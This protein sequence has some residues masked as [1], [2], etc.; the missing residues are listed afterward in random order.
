MSE[1][2]KKYKHAR[3]RGA[4]DGAQWEES[5]I[6]STGTRPG[7]GTR[8]S[9]STRRRPRSPGSLHVGHVL[10][11]HP[12]GSDRAL[13]AHAGQ[14]HRL[15]HGVGRQRPAHRA[16]GAE[17]LRHP[18][19]ARACP[20]IPTGSRPSRQEARRI[21]SR[22]SLAELHRGL[23][24]SITEEDEAASRP[25]GASSAS[26]STGRSSTPRSTSTA[27]ARSRS[28]PS[29]TW[30]RRDLAYS[31][32]APTMWDIDFKTAV[33]QAE[34]EDK[35]APRFMHVI[36]FASRWRSGRRVHHHPRR[37]P[38]CLPAC[39]AVVA[40]PDDERYK[41]YF[42]KKA[43]TPLFG[44]E[45]PIL[46]GRARRPR[47][48]HRASSWSAPSATRWTWSGGSTSGLALKQIIGLDGRLLPVTFGEAPFESVDAARG[49]GALRRA[50]GPLRQAGQEEASPSSSPRTAPA[51]TARRRARRRAREPIDHP[52]KFYEK[53][54]RPLEF[55][56]TRQ[57][58]VKIL[59]H[60]D[61][62]LE[63]GDKIDWHPPFMRTATTLGR[64]PQPGLVHQPPALLR[65]PFPGLVRGARRRASPIYDR[66][67][68]SPT[69]DR[70]PVDPLSRDV[71][72]GTPRIS[73][74]ARRLHGRP[75]RH[76]HLGDELA[77]AADRQPLGRSGRSGTAS[78][79]PW[80]CARSAR[81]H[82][83]L[84]LLHHREGLDAREARSP[85]RTSSSAGGSS[86]PTARR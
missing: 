79:S 53:G 33:A 28:C 20:T 25:S 4:L 36:R 65:R 44:A 5:G 21:P 70:L 1:I 16:P 22:R 23:R 13:P 80:T 57:W 24:R 59:E 49:A 82:P 8:R 39:I 2:P 43:I 14:E 42:G 68:S 27:G 35:R 10:Q 30:S 71:L 17:H 19:R 38:S 48:G 62:L 61:E 9:S 76:G 78:S 11:L 67:R 41:P 86:I 73:A 32:E 83:H 50:R 64:G 55:V 84:G 52:V 77:D 47:E 12:P 40:H 51:R 66:I 58:F 26:R 3:S 75:R 37:A 18:L 56:P 45:V 54:D 60:K 81:D 46:A 85:G 29:S 34:V 72:R 74:A 6:H 31:T 63:Q 69:R 7:D 15:P